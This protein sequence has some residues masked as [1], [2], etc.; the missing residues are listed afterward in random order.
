MSASAPAITVETA[1]DRIGFG[2]FQQRLLLVCGVTWAADAAEIFLIAFALPQV[3]RQFGLDGLESG[4]LATSTFAGMLV[5]AWFWGAISDRIGRRLGFQLTVAIFA[6]FG[7]ASAFA[8]DALWLGVLRFL[9][10]V[11]LGG[12]LP[13]DFSLFAEYLPRRNRGRW[14]V[15]LESF[16]AVGT[17][18]AAGLAWLLV[19]AFGWRPLLATSALAVVLV[20]WIRLQVPESPRYLVTRG[21]GD[22]A[23]QV[24]RR[25][26]ADNGRPLPEEPLTLSPGARARIANLFG[27]GLARDTLGLWGAWL[28]IALAYYGVFVWLPTILVR[29]G[30]GFV[31][32]YQ[33]VFF[34]ALVQL[35]GYFSAAWLVERWGRRRVLA[36][37]LTAAAAA[38]YLWSLGSGVAVALV[39]AGLLS[40]FVL[41]AWAALYALTPEVYPTEIRATGMGVASGWARVGGSV[42]PLVG[43][44]LI[45]VSLVAALSVFAVSFAFA[46]A[47][48]LLV[49]ET[50]GLPLRDTL[51]GS[52]P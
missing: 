26:A 38:T 11:G 5:G 35:P 41:G 14:L 31:V 47:S 2:R 30:L 3:T 51:A 21:R 28:G 42:A 17:V 15:L 43:G 13:L 39:A 34:L 6:L 50:R 49:S 4:L 44:L 24:L 36:T 46:A 23:R 18:A 10:G 7:F 48:A 9:A 52:P 20:L 22:E 40:F 19:P 8:P 1:I 25:V 32:T 45:P 16:W 37:Y 12:A 27:P 33:W 29:E